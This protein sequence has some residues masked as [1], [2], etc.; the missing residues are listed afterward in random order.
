MN[1]GINNIWFPDEQEPILTDSES[2]KLAY[3]HYWK[4]ERDRCINGF[5]LAYAAAQAIA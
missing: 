2:D 3:K 4:R 5:Y 1:T